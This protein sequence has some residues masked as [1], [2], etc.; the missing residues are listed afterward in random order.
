MRTVALVLALAACGGTEAP[1]A[2][3]EPA[4]EP[5]AE[6]EEIVPTHMVEHYMRLT[7][8]REALIRGD[9]QGAQAQL[10]WIAEHEP[11]DDM[12]G[13]FRVSVE[14][15]KA[16]ARAGAYAQTA[17]GVGRGIAAAASTC[18]ECHAAQPEPV[19]FYEVPPPPKKEGLLSEMDRHMWAAERMWHGLIGPSD[20]AWAE[21]AEVL[22]TAPLYSAPEGKVMGDEATA[23]AR[24]VH[25]AGTG[26]LTA[27]SPA[28]RIELYGDFLSACA[29]CH[30]E[31]DG[32]PAPSPALSKGPTD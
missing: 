28:E 31:T 11:T 10:R 23:F 17:Q 21:A 6:P 24:Q 14:R 16:A 32:G 3:P 20:G 13:S 26:T 30:E 4:A 15:M 12:E 29:E 8:A 18:G 27:A 1:P 19:V 2:A 22:A 9:L 25:D 7:G 5:A